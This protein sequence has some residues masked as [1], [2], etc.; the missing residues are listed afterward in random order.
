MHTWAKPDTCQGSLMT[1]PTNSELASL[2]FC[3]YETLE[4]GSACHTA[5]SSTQPSPHNNKQGWAPQ[6]YPTTSSCSSTAHPQ[7][8]EKFLQL[9]GIQ[10]DKVSPY[11]LLHPSPPQIITVFRTISVGTAQTFPISGLLTSIIHC[12]QLFALHL[13]PLW[14]YSLSCKCIFSLIHQP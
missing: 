8:A 5:P 11:P 1:S 4:P 13:S 2:K 9:Q 7:T 6:A 12:P 14:A 3:P 10:S